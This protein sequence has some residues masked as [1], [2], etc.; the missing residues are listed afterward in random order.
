MLPRGRKIT[1]ISKM[2]Q[3]SVA[4]KPYNNYVE[5]LNST[6]KLPSSYQYEAID[7]FAGCGGL[8][9]GFEAAGIKT[10][11]YEILED[12]CKTYSENLIGNCCCQKLTVESK[13]PKVDIVIGGPPCQ[14]FSVS[15]KQLGK[16]DERNGFP[17]FVSAIS[18][19]KPKLFLFENVRGILYKNRDYFDYVIQQLKYLG[20]KTSYM[21]VN[22]ADYDVP[23]NRE[24][25]I[26]VGTLDKPFLFPAANEY[27][28]TA[29]EAVGDIV[30]TLTEDALFLTPSMDKY[31]ANYEKKSH[32]I[33]PR[34]LHMDRPA[35]T[36][37]CRNLAGA[38]SDMQRVRLPDGRRRRLTVREAAR[39]QT[40]P[41]W[42][43]FKGT[44]ESQY[45]Q[46]G[47]AV[48]PFLAYNIAKAMIAHIEGKSYNFEYKQLSLID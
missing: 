18:Q 2:K 30:N 23:Q 28:V 4:A 17:I 9:L 34:D 24:R 26:C 32:C 20:Y 25:V 19:L 38:T 10:F 45:N 36:L 5:Y 31:I 39:L 1:M 21:L 6:L 3:R 47:N 35:R 48:P 7:L 14:P 22:A 42:F 12:C 43:S 41:D 37:T 8:S 29:G 44:K 15:G 16:A 13:F 33:T 11:G 40:F 46:I 27:V